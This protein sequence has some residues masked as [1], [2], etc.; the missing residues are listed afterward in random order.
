VTR[1][2]E[3]AGVSTLSSHGLRHTHATIL[4]LAGAHPKVVGE[5][6]GH[7]DISTTLRVYSHV[8]PQMHEHA[9]E[10][11]ARALAAT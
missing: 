11:F 5:R 8:L 4:M 9:A 3:Q 1:L 2:V 10:L 7:R 6:L